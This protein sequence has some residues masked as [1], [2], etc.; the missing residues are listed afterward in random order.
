MGHTADGNKEWKERCVAEIL[1][2]L[3]PWNTP[4][5]GIYQALHTQLMTLKKGT[6]QDLGMGA[7]VVSARRGAA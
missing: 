5:S 1:D 3:V 6:L 2:A 7:R 4:E